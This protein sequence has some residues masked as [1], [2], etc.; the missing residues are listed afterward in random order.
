MLSTCSL[1]P[2][3]L[4]QHCASRDPDGREKEK[5]K[6][7]TR[8]KAEMKAHK[9]LHFPRADPLRTCQ[10][11]GEHQKVNCINA[12]WHLPFP[13]WPYAAIV[14]ELFVLTCVRMMPFPGMKA[15]AFR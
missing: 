11:R 9:M 4:H 6:E 14:C 12:T 3:T 13:A 10:T 2:L 1:S 8:E 7:D 5:M 15:T